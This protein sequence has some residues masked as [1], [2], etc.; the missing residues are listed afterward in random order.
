MSIHSKFLHGLATALLVATFGA[1]A[2][3]GATADVPTGRE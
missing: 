2:A 3:L 1:S